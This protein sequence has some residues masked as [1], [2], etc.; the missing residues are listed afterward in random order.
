[1]DSRWSGA[2]GRGG[3]PQRTTS[4]A[5]VPSGGARHGIIVSIPDLRFIG[6]VLGLLLF[7]I[8]LMIGAIAVVDALA[9][10]GNWH[11]M[12]G[13]SAPIFALGGS[14]ILSCRGGSFELDRRQAFLLTLLSWLTLVSFGALPFVLGVSGMSYTDAFFEAMSALTTTGSTVL[15]NLDHMP[16]DLLLWRG[17]MQWIGGIG[18]IVMAVAML[19]FLK[20]GGMQLFRMESS[21]RSAKVLPRL[22]DFVGNIVV[23][24]I[25]LT[26]LCAVAFRMAGMTV[27]EAAVHAMTTISTGGF[28]T[29]DQSIG[30]FRSA[31]IEWITIL[32][33]ILGSLPFVLYIQLL[34]GYSRRFWIDRQVGVLLML[35]LLSALLLTLWMTMH[36]PRSPLELFRAA[37]FN[38]V[39]VVT[40]TGF[41]SE[42]YSLW[43]EAPAMAFFFLTFIG[44]CAGSTSGGM[45]VYRLM[46]AFE[47]LR[48]TMQRLVRPHAVLPH[49]ESD[50]KLTDALITSVLTFLFVYVA[51]VG[52][53][54]LGLSLVGLDLMTSL[55][56]AATAVGNVGP[57]LGPVIG[58]A[59]NFAPLP[60]S[61]KWLLAAGMLLG[62]LEMMTALVMFRLDFW[63]P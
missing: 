51:T 40:T 56:G 63:R 46:V 22:T 35:L 38:I 7:M 20:V 62:R 58:P 15:T 60:D 24:Y 27:L 11:V 3:T 32:F 23:I 19:P 4:S 41:A 21:D 8:A 26:F 6:Y 14:L 54:T 18:I 30:H 2:T 44:G 16:A 9:E 39:S 55:S 33:M 13:A 61:A 49:R 1:M 5:S 29:S 37:L 50:H 25:L 45:K 43:G 42:D 36:D 31:S 28:S 52:V 48:Q 12:V 10:R 47:L 53:L 17:F 57:G 59:G 34:R